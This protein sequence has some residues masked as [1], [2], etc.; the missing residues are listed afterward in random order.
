VYSIH[1]QDDHA[2]IYSSEMILGTEPF[3]GHA[4]G[5][6]LGKDKAEMLEL[7]THITP[8]LHTVQQPPKPIHLLGIG[9]MDSILAS[10][11]LGI[12]TFDS[13]YPTRAGR[14]GTLFTSKGI[15]RVDTAEYKLGRRPIDDKCKCF[16]CSTYSTSYLYHLY[17]SSEP[18]AAFLGTIH[19]LHQ[20]FELFATTRNKILRNEI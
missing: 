15:V 3:D 19:N 10:V 14:H 12:D 8:L 5:G 6:S 13:C 18:I 11:P 7:L 1:I 2:H 16:T 9:D 4:I 20:M 17:R